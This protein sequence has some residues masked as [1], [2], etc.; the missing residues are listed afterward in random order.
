MEFPALKHLIQSVCESA[1]GHRILLFG[2][3]SLLASFPDADPEVIGVA[4]TIDADFF[5][6]PDDA[7]IR[8]RLDEQLGEDNDYHQTHGYYDGFVDLRLA[9][10]FPE[11]RR[12]RLVPMPGFGHVFALSPMDMAVSGART[13]QRVPVIKT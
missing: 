6:E 3:S 9:N 11:G 12:D 4:V 2:S 5:I 8:Q 1:Q 10:A 7:A 13:H